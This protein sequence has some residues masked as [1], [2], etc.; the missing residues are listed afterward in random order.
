M[1]ILTG[2]WPSLAQVNKLKF[3]CNFNLIET[4]FV[5]VVVVAGAGE[6]DVNGE[7]VDA[8]TASVDAVAVVVAEVSSVLAGD[9]CCS[10]SSFARFEEDV[11][12]CVLTCFASFTGSLK[13][14][15]H[16]GHV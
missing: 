5:V 4:G 9:S 1:C 14:F 13:L 2:N 6:V 3:Y 16:V 12:S 7:A 15:A 11:F 10:F 8:D